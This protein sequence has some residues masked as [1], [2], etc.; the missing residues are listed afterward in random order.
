EDAF[1]NFVYFPLRDADGAVD[2]IVAFG[3]DVTEQVRARQV[4]EAA[5]RQRDV[6]FQMVSHDLRSPLTTIRGL[7]QLLQRQL[8]RSAAPDPERLRQGLSTIDAAT[9]RMMRQI[10]ELIDLART[11]AGQ[12]LTLEREPTDLV[13]LVEEVV[14][15]YRHAASR[16]RF[17]LELGAVE[18]RGEWDRD[19]LH[20]VVSNLVGNAIK[21]SPD[22]GTVRISLEAEP[23]PTAE[24]AV[25]RVRDEGIGIPADDIPYIFDRFR[26]ATNAQ[27]IDG[28]GIGLASVRAIVEQHGGT[29]D[30]T[31]TAGAGSTFTIRVPR[32]PRER[33]DQPAGATPAREERARPASS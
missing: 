19:R 30:V 3:V 8:A 31:S 10:N 6:L 24:H 9:T 26:R 21:Y 25:L 32:L 29:V 1:L 7:S 12:D 20:R 5:A 15:E 11:E 4:I 27:G 2:G 23:A 17:E 33:R 28:T 13:A 18:L 16:H 22:G 14:S